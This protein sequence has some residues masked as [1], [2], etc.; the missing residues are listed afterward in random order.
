MTPICNHQRVV[1]E[2]ILGKDTVAIAERMSRY[3]PDATWRKT[4]E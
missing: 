1:Y 3:D 4:D 2:N